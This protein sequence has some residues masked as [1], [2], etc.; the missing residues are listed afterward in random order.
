MPGHPATRVQP[1]VHVVI[2][3]AS[4]CTCV[5]T[6]QLVFGIVFS[7]RHNCGV[8]CH[9]GSGRAV[10][11]SHTRL[12]CSQTIVALLLSTANT[13]RHSHQRC[14]PADE[15]C[16]GLWRTKRDTRRTEVTPTD[17][18]DRDSRGTASGPGSSS[19]AGRAWTAP[20]PTSYTSDAAWSSSDSNG[21]TGTPP[22]HRARSLSARSRSTTIELHMH[23]L[24]GLLS[25][26]Q[27]WLRLFS[28]IRKTPSTRAR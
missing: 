19:D 1:L 25:C 27:T 6:I 20:D 2:S 13:E 15:E 3:R 18:E 16:C 17:V 14:V 9:L 23:A 8:A 4:V 7:L 26:V 5:A 24:Y 10:L 12:E 22:G 11:G 28:V 21:P